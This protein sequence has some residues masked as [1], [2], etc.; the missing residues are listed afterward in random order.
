M[1][2]TT[3]TWKPTAAEVQR[4]V[5]SMRP[6]IDRFVERDNRLLALADRRLAP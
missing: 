3:T 6:V 2:T 1:T 4:I 5:A